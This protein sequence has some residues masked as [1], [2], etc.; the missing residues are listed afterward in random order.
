MVSCYVGELSGSRAED[1]WHSLVELGPEALPYLV[2]AFEGSDEV[3]VRFELI[4]IVSEYRSGDAAV[5]LAACLNDNEPTVWK[6]A[7]D[8]LV[9]LR[10][11]EATSALL[12]ANG[13]A[14]A[15]KRAW[16]DE[17]IDQ[18]NMNRDEAIRLLEETLG[19]FRFQLRTGDCLS[20]VLSGPSNFQATGK[21]VARYV[22]AMVRP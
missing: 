9:M 8:G 22:I 11:N 10:G 20:Y 2:A 5:F 3:S 16:I 14:H 6:A 17:A 1:A 13:T 19:A 12:A 15:E 7:L 18:L 21:R 4:R